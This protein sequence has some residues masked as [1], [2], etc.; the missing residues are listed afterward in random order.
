MPSSAFV[1]LVVATLLAHPA[2]ARSDLCASL[3]VP[4]ATGLVCH[5]SDE[6]GVRTVVAPTDGRFADLNR[7][8]LRELDRQRDA[9]AWERPD[10]WL[11]S[12]MEIDVS[13]WVDRLK[14]LAREPDSPIAGKEV[15]RTIEMLALGLDRLGR[16]P[17]VGCRK[18]RLVAS[19]Q[20][21]LRCRFG[22]EPFALNL[23][24][25]L[26]AAGDRRFAANIRSVGE[27][28]LRH[29]EA[30]ANSFRPTS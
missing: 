9:L 24:V 7:L 25:R 20:R 23:Q 2:D 1:F 19:G 21:V 28:R 16:L 17:L 27:R 15:Q 14:R 11:Q 12:Q 5:A 6:E 18:P 30:V 22:A 4:E 8:T 13:A 10:R 3:L 26:I 29:F